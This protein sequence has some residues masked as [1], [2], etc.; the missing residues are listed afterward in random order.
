MKGLTF[1]LVF[2]LSQN[3]YALIV[4]PQHLTFNGIE[5]FDPLPNPGI[6][7][8]SPPCEWTAWDD[9]T[10]YYDEN[11]VYVENHY[12]YLNDGSD[13]ILLDYYTRGFVE[14]NFNF[15]YQV[16]DYRITWFYNISGGGGTGPLNLYYQEQFF[17]LRDGHCP[18]YEVFL[19]ESF[20]LFGEGYNMFELTGLGIF[21]NDTFSIEPIEFPSAFVEYPDLGVAIIEIYNQLPRNFQIYQNGFT[22]EATMHYEPLGDPYTSWYATDTF[23]VYI[24]EPCTLL[25]LAF[26]GLMLVRKRRGDL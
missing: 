4:T 7:Y 8:I 10:W 21:C 9:T 18:Q 23:W 14:G 2:I 6:P 19:S 15:H 12:L 22:F 20:I 16:D 13:T 25:L 1:V 24:P 26:G 17:E 5:G 3:L 11:N